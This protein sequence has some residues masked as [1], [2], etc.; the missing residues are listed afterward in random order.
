MRGLEVVL[1]KELIMLPVTITFLQF[2]LILT[3]NQTLHWMVTLT[4]P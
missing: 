2:N 3:L 4:H 1:P